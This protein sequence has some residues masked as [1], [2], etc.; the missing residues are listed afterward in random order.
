MHA[1]SNKTILFIQ[2]HDL[3]LHVEVIIGFDRLE[4]DIPENMGPV[5]VTVRI[6]EGSIAKDV[7]VI[8]NTGDGTAVCKLD[9]CTKYL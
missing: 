3:S 9:T 4:Y 2:S 7:V 5:N 1:R 6:I 8:I